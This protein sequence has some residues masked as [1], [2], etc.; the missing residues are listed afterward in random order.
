VSEPGGCSVRASGWTNGAMRCRHSAV[1]VI[2]CLLAS[3]ETLAAGSTL[4][5]SAKTVTESQEIVVTVA[6]GSN[7]PHELD[8]VGS[9]RKASRR[10]GIHLRRG[11]VALRVGERAVHLGPQRRVPRGGECRAEREVM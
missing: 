3:R 11:Q 5:L 6:N 7:P 9:T 8:W 1:G 2:L 4:A 10:A